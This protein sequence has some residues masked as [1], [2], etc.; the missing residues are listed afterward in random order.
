MS[1]F[2][3]AF[4]PDPAHLARLEV[5]S[6]SHRV[7]ERFAITAPSG[8][9]IYFRYLGDG[10]IRDVQLHLMTDFGGVELRHVQGTARWTLRP[11]PESQPRSTALAVE[12]AFACATGVLSL[13]QVAID[14]LGMEDLPR[15]EI[16]S[17]SPEDRGLIDAHLPAVLGADT[18]VQA[19]L[20]GGAVELARHI[21]AAKARHEAHL[22]EVAQKKRMR[23]Q[24]DLLPSGTVLLENS[25]WAVARITDARGSRTRRSLEVRT[26]GGV[27][28]R[29]DLLVSILSG[30]RPVTPD[31]LARLPVGLLSAHESLTALKQAETLPHIAPDLFPVGGAPTGRVFR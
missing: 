14:M 28:L 3:T 4:A 17:L 10:A 26:F 25:Y 11:S 9:A 6:H 1:R 16:A 2:P 7:T 12:T 15:Q 19:V 27:T 31:E 29:K 21:A 22:A 18:E 5:D 30:Y 20:A 8:R 13:C 23:R 24:L